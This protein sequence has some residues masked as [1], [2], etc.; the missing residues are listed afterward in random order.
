[1]WARMI[2]GKLCKCGYVGK[3]SGLTPFCK[4]FIQITETQIFV[5]IRKCYRDVFVGKYF[6]LDNPDKGIREDKNKDDHYEVKSG[7]IFSEKIGSDGNDVGFLLPQSH[8][9]YFFDG[10]KNNGN[11]CPIRISHVFITN[12]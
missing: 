3:E 6:C 4:V 2:C 10:G 9:Q 7:I 11:F 1:M 5:N 12:I 8:I